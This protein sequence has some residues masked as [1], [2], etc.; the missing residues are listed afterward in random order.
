MRE[1]PLTGWR[2]GGRTVFKGF[3][4]DQQGDDCAIY[5]TREHGGRTPDLVGGNQ[6]VCFAQVV[7][8]RPVSGWFTNGE[9][10]EPSAF[11]WL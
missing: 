2:S 1:S 3:W 10:G 8:K 6:A 5:C 4:R 11:G 7:C 9:T